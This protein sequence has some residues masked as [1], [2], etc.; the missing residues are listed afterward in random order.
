MYLVS[1]NIQNIFGVLSKYD[2]AHEKAFGEEIEKI[3]PSL[4]Q[5]LEDSKKIKINIIV[6][7]LKTMLNDILEAK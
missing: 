5:F 7:N 1:S 3:K 2:D 6:A 4:G